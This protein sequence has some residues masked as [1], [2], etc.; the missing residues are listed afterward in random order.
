[1]S[2]YS[3]DFDENSNKYASEFEDSQFKPDLH[4]EK[5]NLLLSS[6]ESNKDNQESFENNLQALREEIKA[7]E[8]EQLQNLETL[9][10]GDTLELVDDSSED[11][12][13]FIKYHQN[14]VNAKIRSS[15]KKSPS[16]KLD[17]SQ[18]SQRSAQKVGN[19][20]RRKS[21]SKTPI[22]VE[23]KLRKNFD[24]YEEQPQ[25]PIKYIS[26]AYNLKK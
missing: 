21:S 25:S 3:E 19:S 8:I 18:I 7:L 10:S 22:K 5:P 20:Q 16:K 4:A 1:M 17:S 6:A 2:N 9:D 13:D 14:L 24:N 11:D 23:G 15:S 26:K 12:M